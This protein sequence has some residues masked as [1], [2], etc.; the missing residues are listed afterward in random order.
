MEMVKKQQAFAKAVAQLILHADAIGLPV[1]LGDAYRDPRLHGAMGVKQ[2]YGAANSCH[3]LRLALDLNIIK[4]GKLAGEAEYAK[5][6]EFWDTVGGSPFIADDMNH[7]SF[8]H[9]KFR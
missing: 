6:H 5:L 9:G 3:K 7:F 2:G 1:T 4:G 8:Q